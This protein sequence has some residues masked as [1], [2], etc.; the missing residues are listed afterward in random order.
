MNRIGY[1]ENDYGDYEMIEAS[2]YQLGDRICETLIETSMLPK[3]GN[4]RFVNSP[5]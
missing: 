3:H 5:L 2:D 1:Y 4:G